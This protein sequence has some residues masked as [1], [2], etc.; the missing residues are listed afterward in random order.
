MTG[1]QMKKGEKNEKTKIDTLEIAA[2][3]SREHITMFLNIDRCSNSALPLF[4]L[5]SPFAS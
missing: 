3:G 5:V 2:N 4:S 1:K